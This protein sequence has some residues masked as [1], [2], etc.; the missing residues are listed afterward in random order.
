[1]YASWNGDTRASSWKVL[2]GSGGGAMGAVAT[3]PKS[4]FETAIPVGQGYKRFKVEALDAGG[5]VIGSSGE[6]AAR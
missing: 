3:K 4:G 1:V 6:F 2:A 5:R